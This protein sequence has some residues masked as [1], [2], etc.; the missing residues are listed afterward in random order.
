MSRKKNNGNINGNGDRGGNNGKEEKTTK[1]KKI[2]AKEGRH[3][4]QR[5]SITAKTENQKLLLRSIKENIITIVTGKPG[6]GKTLLA[7]VS[8]LREF[9][10]KKYSKMIFTRPCVEANHENLGFLPGGLNEKISPY[11]YPIFDFLSDYLSTKQI[12]EYMKE[13][14]IKTFP[15]AFM[16]GCTFKNAFILLDESQNTTIEQMRMFLTRIGE[17]CKVVITG[18]PYQTDIKDKNGLVDACE[19]LKGINNLGIV[20]FGEEDILRSSIIKDID[21]RYYIEN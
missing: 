6:T 17:N 4:E 9:S 1:S 18:D 2:I 16:R 21:K 5:I 10:M 12:E 15:L 3:Q 14:K 11:M 13:E 8:G 7:V 20:R 19:R